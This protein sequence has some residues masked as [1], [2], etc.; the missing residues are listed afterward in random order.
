MLLE[1]FEKLKT[2]WHGDCPTCGRHSRMYKRKLHTGI[3]LA[4]IKLFHAGGAQDF[5]H[6]SSIMTKKD[7]EIS[8]FDI[9]IARFWKL[10]E[11]REKAPDKRTKSSGQWKL[12]RHGQAFVMNQLKI[13]KYAMLFDNRCTGFY[14]D[15]VGIKDCLGNKFNYE[16]LMKGV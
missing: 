3:A 13:Q 14:G 10:V 1:F 8:G 7:E 4:L 5:V 9:S 12:T 11:T 16:E 2:G 15:D 6:I